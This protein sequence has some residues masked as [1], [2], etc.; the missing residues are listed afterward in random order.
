MGGRKRTMAIAAMACA[1]AGLVFAGGALAASVGVTNQVAASDPAK[2]HAGDTIH[3][4]LSVTNTNPNTAVL[5]VTDKL[6]DGSVTTLDSGRT[7][8]PGETANYTLDYA[9]DPAD[10]SLIAG[11]NVLVNT[12]HVEGTEVRSAPYVPDDIAATVTKSSAIIAPAIGIA[13][14]VDFDGDGIYTD[15]ETWAPRPASWKIVVSN[16]GDAPLHDVMVTDTNG[17][18]FGPYSIAV[19]GSVTDVYETD[20]AEDTENTATATG[21][22]ETKRSVGPVSDSARV[23]VPGIDIDLV[24]T[25]NADSIAGVLRGT[26][27]TYFFT[28]TN[29][30]E[31]TLFDVDVVDDKIGLIGTIPVL[32]PGDSETLSGTNVLMG[33]TTNVATA[34]GTDKYERMVSDTSLVTIP[35]FLPFPPDLEILKSAEVVTARPGELVVFTLRY[36]NIGEEAVESYTITDDYDE[37]YVDVADSNGGVDSGGK[38][39]WTFEET[40]APEDGWQSFTYSVRL[41]SN[42]PAGTTIDNIVVIHNDKDTNPDNDSDDWRL[43]TPGKGEPFLPFTGGS[44][45]L[46]GMLALLAAAIGLVVRWASRGRNGFEPRRSL[47]AVSVSRLWTL[48]ALVLL[49]AAL[50]LLSVSPAFAANIEL[51]KR[52]TAAP[53]YYRVGDTITYNLQVK[54][55]NANSAVLNVWDVKPDGSTK[56]LATGVTFAAGETRTYTADYV[57]RAQDIETKASGES[58][59]KFVRNTLYAEGYEQRDVPDYMYGMVTENSPVI[60]PALAI[61]KTV[62]FNADGVFSDSETYVAGSPAVW[63]IVV[64]NTGDTPLTDVTV[65][66]TNAHGFGASFAL[67]SGASKTFEYITVPQGDTVNEATAVGT[68]L[69]GLPVGPVSDAADV[70]VRTSAIRV[71]KTVEFNGDGVFTHEETGTAGMAVWKLMVTN[72]GDTR[73]TD[74]Y[75]TDTNGRTFGPYTLEPGASA[76]E[77]YETEIAEDTVNEVSA[78]GIDMFGLPVGPA[79]DSAR[80]HVIA[81]DISLEKT[82]EFD[83]DGVFTHDETGPAGTAQWKLVVTNSG[84]ATLY[85]VMVTDTNGRSFGPIAELAAGASE[86]F[87]Y[88]TSVEQDTLNVALAQGYDENGAEY[89]ATDEAAVHV[90]RGE[91]TVEKTVDADGDGEFHDTETY[92]GPLAVVG[93]SVQCDGPPPVFDPKA[94]WKIVVTNSGECTLYDVV[95]DDT[96]GKSFGPI[97]ELA[98]GASETFTY[99]TAITGEVVNVATAEG[100]DVR[101]RSYTDTDD[102]TLLVKDCVGGIKIEKTVDADGDGVF[103]DTETIYDDGSPAGS[104]QCVPVPPSG[105][106]VTW[107]IVV[108]NTGDCDLTDVRIA[109]SN[110]KSFGPISLASGASKTYTYTTTVTKDTVNTATATGCDEWNRTYTDT[111]DATVLVLTKPCIGG[112]KIEKTVDADGDGVFHDTETYSFPALASASGIQ[113]VPP[114]PPPPPAPQA[115]WKIVVTNTGQCDLT[116]V[117]IA[118]SNGKSFGP[119]SLASGAS[120]TYTY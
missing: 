78:I 62:D 76:T 50:A 53:V 31:V 115:T 28:V 111:D 81:P 5:T 118:D 87:D 42:V 79:T 54:N 45:T 119:I 25:A 84:D 20:V 100:F 114:P 11:Q 1:I 9:A 4:R 2:Y 30:G 48:G 107:K 113:C 80:V 16:T 41:K 106:K 77:S 93:A 38:I 47:K 109:D 35:V 64:T 104:I 14:T 57:V 89:T 17:K 29:T 24:K 94:T 108:T 33:D 102:A 112:I 44:G 117:R 110:G 61:D 21:L 59:L 32:E 52:A 7:F 68:A 90:C 10:S 116:D 56:T 75:M 88:E 66:D 86:T 12:L 69:D 34:T 67:A 98:P 92:V 91:I 49:T 55:T 13:K 97:A 70:D 60:E 18:S 71:S 22:D 8:A 65:T 96:N 40:L 74:V 43:T 3:Y 101:G 103:H 82:V 39:L 37:R 19:G 73:L 63:K 51:S 26:E 6:P 36:R 15:E 83:G 46:L 95:V 23:I 85:D 120:K 72:A 99:K 58:T 105:A 27:V